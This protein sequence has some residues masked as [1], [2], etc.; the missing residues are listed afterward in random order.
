MRWVS[1]LVAFACAA[2]ASSACLAQV[3]PG[4][5]DAEPTFA[6]ALEAAWQRSPA[7]QSAQARRD[8]QRAVRSAAGSVTPEPPSVTLSQR[9]D[10]LNSNRGARETE[11]ELAWPLWLPGARAAALGVAAAEADAV[12]GQL[13]FSRLK[14]ASEVREAVW[15]VRLA[16][17]ELDASTRRVAE[18]Q[19]LAADVQRRVTAGDSARTDGNQAQGLVQ[20]AQATQAEARGRLLRAERIYA[21]LTGLLR[22]PVQAEALTPPPAIEAHPQIVSTERAATAARARL[23]NASVATRDPPELTVGVRSERSAFGDSYATSARIGV[24]VPFGTD[25]RNQ[26]RI[27]AAGA[28]LL[29][30][31]AVARLERDRLQAEID[32]AAAELEQSRRIEQFATELARLAADTQQLL[33]KAFRL[34]EVDLPTRLRTEKERFDAELALGRAR[35]EAG[36]AVSRLQQ[37]Y[38]ML[39]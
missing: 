34:G 23:R 3:A 12:D 36:R 26:P 37:A 15:A 27:T 35:L 2:A 25:A 6:Q 17:A 39:P 1:W 19:A 28:E 14:L 30:I 9:S 10:R 18:A 38:G 13:Q 32:A 31:E 16:Q 5:G 24:R 29:E 33:A 21:A 20:L 22:A 11:V 7:G 4:I 8:Q